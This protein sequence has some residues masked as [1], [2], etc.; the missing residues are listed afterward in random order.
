MENSNQMCAVWPRPPCDTIC[1]LMRVFLHSYYGE[2]SS[3]V[4]H[5]NGTQKRNGDRSQTVQENRRLKLDTGQETWTDWKKTRQNKAKKKKG[6][7]ESSHSTLDNLELIKRDS[8]ISKLKGRGL[9][10]S[11]LLFLWVIISE[12]NYRISTLESRLLI[13]K[14]KEQGN[15]WS[16][17][18]KPTVTGTLLH[19]HLYLLHWMWGKQHDI[20]EQA[21][22]KGLVHP[23]L[24]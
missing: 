8:R 12:S 16:S 17:G 21:A 23:K 19:L 1:F 5:F 2:L 6:Y 13:R 20:N 15:I 7:C 4:W 11:R 22:F 24:K 9:I 3:F 18:P 10:C 14:N